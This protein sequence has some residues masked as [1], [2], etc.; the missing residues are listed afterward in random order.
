MFYIDDEAVVRPLAGP[1]VASAAKLWAERINPTWW[2]CRTWVGDWLTEDR[3]TWRT[4]DDVW[5]AQIQRSSNGKHTF[6][7]LWREGAYAGYQ[8]DVGWHP[9]TANGRV[10]QPGDTLLGIALAYYGDAEQSERIFQANLGR[11]QT[12]GRQF[13]RHGLIA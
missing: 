5:L 2:R 4:T 6:L 7:A 11:E 3:V 12:D 9:A 13:N 8:D 1:V 10:R